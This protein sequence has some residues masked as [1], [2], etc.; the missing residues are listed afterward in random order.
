MRII[1]KKVLIALSVS[2]ALTACGK[3]DAEPKQSKV[4]TEKSALVEAGPIKPSF[5]IPSEYSNYFR[6]E[7]T[8]AEGE[9]YSKL[10]ESLFKSFYSAW[11]KQLVSVDSPN[12][13]IITGLL[14]PE[15]TAEPNEFKRQEA[16]EKTK[17]ESNPDKGQLNVVVGYLGE[18]APEFKLLDVNTGEYQI[19]IKTRGRYS[20]GGVYRNEKGYIYRLNYQINF[21]HFFTKVDIYN[22][23][24]IVPIEKAK[25]IESLKGVSRTIIRVYGKVRKLKDDEV[26][27][28]SNYA[29][30]ALEVD[31]EAIEFGI[32][33]N[34]EF[35]SLLFIDGGQLKK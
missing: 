22:R 2:I 8:E 5:Q 11:F 14:H 19:D 33:Q 20:S 4:V 13:T 27:I 17:L 16:I 10:P 18:Y 9:A 25:E 15:F 28:A 1:S 3:K 23:K 34:G 29:D 24:V 26:A 31:A 7:V 21:D 6:M 32:R 30:A 35:K 12:W